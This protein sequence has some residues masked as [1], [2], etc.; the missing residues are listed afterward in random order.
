MPRGKVEVFLEQFP[1]VKNHIRNAH[2]VDEVYVSGMNK[3]FLTMPIPGDLDV[4]CNWGEKIFLL[5]EEG[6]LVV[7]TETIIRHRRR[8]WIFGPIIG[9]SKDTIETKGI[10]YPEGSVDL[11]LRS[12]GDNADSVRYALSYYGCGSV[13]CVIV[14]KAPKGMSINEWC[15]TESKKELEAQMAEIDSAVTV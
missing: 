9:E 1:W 12:L 11:T 3:E 15:R 5:D 10:V 2:N 13:N 6:K 14:Y 4:E 8:F 7:K